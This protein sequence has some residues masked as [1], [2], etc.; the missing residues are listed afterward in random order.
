MIPAGGMLNQEKQMRKSNRSGPSIATRLLLAA[1]L[2]GSAMTAWIANPAV[3]DP[4][5]TYQ[6]GQSIEVREGDTWS[7]AT[8][9]RREGRRYLIHYAGSDSSSDEWVG[10]DRMRL[11]GSTDASAAPPAPTTPSGSDEPRHSR[12]GNPNDMFPMPDEVIPQT[13]PNRSAVDVD[14]PAEAP[15]AW[16]VVADP[17][18]RPAAV[19]SFVLRARSADNRMEVQQLLPCAGGGAVVGFVTPGE[20]ARRVERVGTA[21]GAAHC[22]LP[23][24]SLP[25]AAGPTGTLLVCRCNA[26]GFGNNARIDA[27]TL[28]AGTPVAT[29]LV[30]FTPYPP[31]DANGKGEDIRFAAALSES[32]I[33]T[34]DGRGRLVAWD[35]ASNSVT[36]VWRVDVGRMNFGG[37]G[38]N[39]ALSPGGRWLA[40]ASE[41]GL[42][43]VE[44]ATGHVLGVIPTSLRDPVYNLTCSP[45]GKTLVASGPDDSL[46]SFDATTGKQIRIVALP[47]KT[48]GP[49]TCVDDGFALIGGKLIDTNTGAVVRHSHPPEGMNVTVNGPGVTL[50]ANGSNLLAVHIPD[51][52]TRATALAA[53]DAALALEPGMSVAVDIQLDMSDKD[54]AAVDA[55]IRKKLTDDG[56]VV[57]PSADT[58]VVCRTEP[59][60][61]HEHFYTKTQAGMPVFMGMGGGTSVIVADKV[62]RITI[63]QKGQTIWERLRTVG[64]AARFLLKDGQ[65]LEDGAKET[66]HY[67]PQFLINIAIPPYIAKP[68]TDVDK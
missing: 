50:M 55:A 1:A 43:F 11:P 41:T 58:V 23:P 52:A 26:F 24:Q 7:A 67:D 6:A 40:A 19:H 59:G 66:I 31:E 42:T 3:A 32:R 30:S 56:F 38:V 37:F 61:Q 47:D 62:T 5:T 29:P 12:H 49:M 20:K 35:I 21:S 10:T 13:E 64:P 28:T 51:A 4:P 14:Q 46:V 22:A 9:I 63:Q 8:I 25:L 18:A 16:S 68:Q 44:A 15:A 2:A 65:S 60:A 45:T 53:E 27:F 36:G 57:A 39:V 48:F 54:R 33:V 17:A 34:C